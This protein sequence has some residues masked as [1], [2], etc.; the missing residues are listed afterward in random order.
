MRIYKEVKVGIFIICVG[1][2]FLFGLKFLR[3]KNLFNVTGN[4]IITIFSETKGLMISNPVYINGFQVGAVSNIKA[5][6]RYL[7]S[8]VVDIKLNGKYAIPINSIAS[9]IKD[10]IGIPS[11]DI[12]LGNSLSYVRGNYDTILTSNSEGI[13]GALANRLLPVASNI[14]QA[15]VGINNFVDSLTLILNPKTRNHVEGIIYNMHKLAKNLVLTTSN[16]NELMVNHNDSMGS[17]AGAVKAIDRITANI[18]NN[19][20]HINDIISNVDNFSHTINQVQLL[21]LAQDM[22]G[23]LEKLTVF[24]SDIENGTGTASALL[25]DKSLYNNLNNTIY[26]LHILLDDIRLHPKR[27][28]QVSVFGKKNKDELLQAPVSSYDNK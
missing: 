19:Q 27:Y 21:G 28:I 17:I 1:V 14:Q 7:T 15:A 5:A 26:S 2:L 8:I 16:I 12:H 24:I 23:A 3:G 22:Q 6:N 20:P 9:I 11:I 18:N 25:H 10:P 13:L 4:T